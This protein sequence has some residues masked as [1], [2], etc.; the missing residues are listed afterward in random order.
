MANLCEKCPIADKI[1]ICCSSNPETGET[2]PMRF[3]K[4]RQIIRVCNNLA[5]DGTCE[6]YSE[7][8]EA[9]KGY[10]CEELY[11]MGLNSER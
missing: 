3:I 5:S 2:K 11:A 4:S 10:A 8:P 9:C 7:R 6:I 1:D